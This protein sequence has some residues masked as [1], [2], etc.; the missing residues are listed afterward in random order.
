M[1]HMEKYLKMYFL[2][3]AETLLELSLAGSL[4]NIHKTRWSWTKL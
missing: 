2:K 1:T 3:T 4:E